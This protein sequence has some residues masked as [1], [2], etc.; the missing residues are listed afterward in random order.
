MKQDFLKQVGY[1]IDYQSPISERT[2]GTVE[3][4]QKLKAY[5]KNA[6]ENARRLQTAYQEQKRIAGLYKRQRD[7]YE[8]KNNGGADASFM[9]GFSTGIVFGVVTAWIFLQM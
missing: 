6:R 1:A 3:K 2:P 4:L 5:K 9:I 7:F 8:G